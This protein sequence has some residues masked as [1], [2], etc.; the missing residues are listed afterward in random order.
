[1]KTLARGK[2]LL[3]LVFPREKARFWAM[4]LEVSGYHE[5]FW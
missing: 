2:A 3:A 5:R 1:M 4:S